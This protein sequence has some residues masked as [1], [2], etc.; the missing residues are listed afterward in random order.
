MYFKFHCGKSKVS[1]ADH[2]RLRVVLTM[3]RQVE[4]NWKVINYLR[5]V[6]VNMFRMER[7]GR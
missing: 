3:K 5:A 6:R 7:M 4:R 1:E 2:Q